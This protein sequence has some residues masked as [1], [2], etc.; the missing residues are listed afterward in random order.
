LAKEPDSEYSERTLKMSEFTKIV[1]EEAK[2]F[3][4]NV[5][6]ID[7]EIV[8]DEQDAKPEAAV[9]VEPRRGA[10]I[11]LEDDFESRPPVGGQKLRANLMITEFAKAGILCT[12]LN[13]RYITEAYLDAVLAKA[14]VIILDWE[15]KFPGL[16]RDKPAENY[17][18]NVIRKLIGQD[19]F[20]LVIIYTGAGSEDIDSEME[21]A[22]PLGS[23]VVWE[24]W[25]KPSSLRKGST[26][27]YGELPLKII[28][29]FA[30]ENSGI[31][32]AAVLRSL[33][34]I[35]ENS[36]RLLNAFT[37]DLDKALLYHRML[38]PNSEDTEEFC[39][40]II[41]DEFLG[42]LKDADLGKYI[43]TEYCE[44]YIAEKE[45]K[46]LSSK[47]PDT[48]YSQDE[49]KRFLATKPDDKDVKRICANIKN[50]DE[51]MLKQ[52]SA[53]STTRKSGNS[54]LRLGCILE[55]KS[56]PP[57]YYLC[58]QPPCDSVRIKD[59]ASFIFC[60]LEYNPVSNISFYINDGKENKSFK[61]DYRAKHVFIF[62]GKDKIRLDGT[63]V[64]ENKEEFT[65]IAQLK[66]MFAQKIANEFA[67]YISRIGIDQFEWLRLKGK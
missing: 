9:L 17:C 19:R 4:S 41:A 36:F 11:S 40:D 14:D 29:K 30:A 32:P 60:G 33:T 54:F 12:P 58:L 3:I 49:L 5:L 27:D 6:C 26:T 42:I 57:E 67:A 2:K 50:D 8:Y 35:R 18:L 23:N 7:D 15:F 61:I 62:Y 20:R 31:L 65:C 52:F 59:R 24:I 37:K 38:I 13:P 47:N 63:L 66:P 43:S 10:L 16:L 56:E 64:S 22:C 21:E 1:E 48:C 53:L 44:K 28:K 34:G 55:L 46:F 39:G 51:E 45:P 25:G